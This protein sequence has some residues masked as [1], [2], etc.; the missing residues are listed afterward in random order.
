MSP[1]FLLGLPLHPDA[2]QLVIHL[3]GKL[4]G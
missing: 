4:S 2:M 1:L 3:K